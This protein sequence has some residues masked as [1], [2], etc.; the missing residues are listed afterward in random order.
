M[1]NL[2]TLNQILD[3]IK[4][5]A[6][7]LVGL[8]ALVL[9][10]V[11][12]VRSFSTSDISVESIKIPES[13]AE[14]G[15]TSEITTLQI[16]DEIS[17]IHELSSNSFNVSKKNIGGNP[18]GDNLTRL[19]SLPGA[20]GIDFKTIQTLIQ[21]TFGIRKEKITGEITG[22]NKD[23]IVTYHV[24]VR[25]MPDNTLLVDFNEQS[26]IPS[27]IKSTALRLVER[28]EP[29]V[30]ATYYRRNKDPANAL[31]LLDEALRNKDTSDDVSALIQRASLFMQEGKISLAQSDLNAAFAL[32]P[33]SPQALNVQSVLFNQ[34]KKYKQALETAQQQLEAWP[35]R[36]NTYANMAAAYV[37]L[38][39]D[40]EAEKNYVKSIT[41]IP[42]GI[43][44]YLEAASYFSQ[45]EKYLL[46]EQALD[47]GLKRYPD[48]IFLL[49][50]YSSVMLKLNK[51]DL[52]ALALNKAFKRNPEDQ[53]IWSAVLRL[54][55]DVDQKLTD[56][57][58]EMTAKFS[59][60]QPD[61]EI[62]RQL[63]GNK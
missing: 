27:L 34:Q 56:Q 30:A 45:K 63:G 17:K 15:Y 59:Q 21:E 18:S 10:S 40:D 53:S 39:N 55:K 7:A 26:D 16:L 61:S 49:I 52:A 19:A 11:V 32:E 13:F 22:K 20:G 42:R 2:T 9:V 12:L 46:A 60:V 25:T 29:A 4:N 6:V 8:F 51:P 47:Q 5:A 33:K 35:D 57:V 36:W 37:G 23:G 43:T 50:D 38:G 48:D 54:P 1:P 44:T 62:A 14:A 3:T 41:L 31:R 28:L 58:V 24:R